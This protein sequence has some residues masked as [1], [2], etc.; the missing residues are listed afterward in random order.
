M[1]S[2]LPL[3]AQSDI[4]LLVTPVYLDGMTGPMKTFID[5]LIPLLEGRVEIREGHLRH[6]LRESVKRGKIALMSASGFPELDTFDPLVAHVKAISR[7]LGREYAGE[8]LIP[9]GWHLRGQGDWD[10]VLRLIESAGAHIV[11]EGMIPIGISSKI[12]SLVSREEVA[13]AV[14]AI[15]S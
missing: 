11:K 2:L 7:N 15:Y 1:E 4:L 5:R 14:N 12:H 10:A 8:V 13:R 3:V 6:P 9:S